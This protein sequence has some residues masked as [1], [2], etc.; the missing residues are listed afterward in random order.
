[1]EKHIK[2]ATDIFQQYGLD[3]EMAKRAGGWTNAVWVNGNFVLRLSKELGS[4]KIRREVA[5]SKILPSSVGYPKNIA[6]GV[7]DGYEWSLSER[8]QGEA[9]SHIWNSLSWAEKVK[10]VKEIIDITT[11]VHCAPVEKIAH[12]TLKT[13]WYNQ[14][15]KEKSLADFNNYVAKGLFTPEQGKNLRD[16]LERFYQ[17]KTC[18]GAVLCHGDITTDNLLWHDGNVVSLLDFEHAVIA[19]P[20]LDIH[21]VVNLALVPYDEDTSM[22]NILFEEE[23]LDI[24]RYVAEV[25]SLFKPFLSTQSDKELFLGYHILFR[26]KFLEFWLAD[27]SGDIK[28]CDAY[29]KLLSLSDGNGGYLSLLLK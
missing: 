5:H 25:L 28:E 20:L 27:P 19:P 13:A 15:D 17:W 16:I 21:S 14:F 8:V 29:Q 18:T 9:L 26:Q 2:I 1:M 3:F 24:Q 10:A 11:A 12:L 23:N 22:D 7:T 6:T 4:D